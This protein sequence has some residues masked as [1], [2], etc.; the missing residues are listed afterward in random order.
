[1]RPVIV[2]A[3][4]TQHGHTSAEERGWTDSRLQKY[5]DF[6]HNASF[7]A[8]FSIRHHLYEKEEYAE[9]RDVMHHVRHRISFFF[10]HFSA[11]GPP[12]HLVFS[13][14][15]RDATRP[16]IRRV[17]HLFKFHST[18]W[19]LEAHPPDPYG[20]LMSPLGGRRTAIGLPSLR[21]GPGVG[22]R[23]R[24]WAL[25]PKGGQEGASLFTFKEL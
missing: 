1:M 12:P 3:D 25:P 19:S 21:E 2:A 9:S 5:K 20:P 24:G 15:G 17:F 13:A 6:S 22:H 10:V 7:S 4:A 11:C 18:S 23:G 8:F 16:Y 14:C